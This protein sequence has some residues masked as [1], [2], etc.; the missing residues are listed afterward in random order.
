MCVQ[1]FRGGLP[2]RNAFLSIPDFLREQ[3]HCHIV[4]LRSQKRSEF[5]GDPLPLKMYL[6]ADRVGHTQHMDR[7]RQHRAYDLAGLCCC[8]PQEGLPIPIN[9][10]EQPAHHA[11][12][13]RFDANYY[14]ATIFS[15]S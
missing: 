1:A 8:G 2:L 9:L 7:I 10:V 15:A 3:F 13:L 14:I 4:E 11:K 6:A 5:L 12:Y